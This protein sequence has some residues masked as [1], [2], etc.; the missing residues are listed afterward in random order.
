VSTLRRVVATAEM[1]GRDLLR[2]RLAL[3]LL[4][5]LPV[6]FYLSTRYTEGGS[7]YTSGG[8]GLS[9]SIA[10]AALYSAL[11]ARPVDRRLVLDGYRPAELLAGRVLLLETFGIVLSAA[12]TAVMWGF[13]TPKD[14]PALVLAMLLVAVVAVPFGLAIA[15]LVPRELE[16]T[17]V[18]IGVV[19]I[20]MSLPSSG[21]LEGVMPFGAAH[22]LLNVASGHQFAVGPCLAR[23][24][25]WA[26]LLLV[27]AIAAWWE[28]VHVVRHERARARPHRAGLAALVAAGAIA[29]AV[30]AYPWQTLRVQPRS[31]VASTNARADVARSPR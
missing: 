12:F 30:I 4:V 10:G 31:P 15:G 5:A 19:G 26:V 2:R 1:L 7:G 24:F 14:G 11:A 3:V 27:V 28:R 17:L 20:E 13:V 21:T 25:A 23:G 8:I 22:R 18:L 6:A 16:G 9:W 29:I